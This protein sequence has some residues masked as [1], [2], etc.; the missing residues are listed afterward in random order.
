MTPH[1]LGGFGLLLV[2]AAQHYTPDGLLPGHDAARSGYS[3]FARLKQ[4][5][6]ARGTYPYARGKT[7]YA[8]GLRSS[9]G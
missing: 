3:A 5:D 8:R 9:P 6:F 1:M 4:P 2:D 7:P